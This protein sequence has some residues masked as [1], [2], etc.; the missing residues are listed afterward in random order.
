[1]ENER[2]IKK[3]TIEFE[4]GGKSEITKGFLVDFHD[5]EFDGTRTMTFNLMNIKGNELKDVVFAVLDFAQRIGMVDDLVEE[6]D[7]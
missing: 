3:I 4:D 1:M 5:D 7:E 2:N 6:E